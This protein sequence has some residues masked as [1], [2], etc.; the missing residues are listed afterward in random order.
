M[1]RV[2]PAHQ[3][4]A[5]QPEQQFHLCE[6]ALDPDVTHVLRNPVFA[7]EVIIDSQ[8]FH[9][10]VVT[11]RPFAAQVIEVHCGSPAELISANCT[12]SFC[13]RRVMRVVTLLGLM[14]STLAISSAS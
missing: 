5:R 8:V 9:Q 7:Q 11:R 4:D 2:E 14:P 13:F 12:V 10:R 1:L 6:P 3:C